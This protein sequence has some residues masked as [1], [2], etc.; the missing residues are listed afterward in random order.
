MPE[1]LVV[2]MVVCC[3]VPNVR[4]HMELTLDDKIDYYTSHV[5]GEVDLDGQEQQSLVRRFL[6][7]DG[8]E[9]HELQFQWTSAYGC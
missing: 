1:D 3:V 9:L 5:E 6:S 4:Q 2:A 7:E 8:S